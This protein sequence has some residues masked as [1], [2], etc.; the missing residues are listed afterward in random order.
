MSKSRY[1]KRKRNVLRNRNRA[2]IGRCA[3][4]SL[5]LGMCFCML[6]NLFCLSYSLFFKIYFLV[7]VKFRCKYQCSLL[8]GNLECSTLPTRYSVP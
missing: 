7:A 4:F 1:D 6:I 8:C 3:G 5:V 2:S